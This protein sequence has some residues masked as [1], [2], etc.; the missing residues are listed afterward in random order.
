M[1]YRDIKLT[2][3]HPELDVK[4]VARVIVRKG[5]KP[6]EAKRAVSL[7]VDADVSSGSRLKALAT[8]RA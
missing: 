8:K 7:R 3:E 6:L 4:H 2:K 5:L 1:K